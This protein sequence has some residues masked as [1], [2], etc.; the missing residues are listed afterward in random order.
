LA[1]V[2]PSA[3]GGV[4]KTALLIILLVLALGALVALGF[5]AWRLIANL[6][7][8]GRSLARSQAR[9]APIL[10]SLADGSAS[11]TEQAAR[12]QARMEDRAASRDTA[13]S[14]YGAGGGIRDGG[15]RD[16][17]GERPPGGDGD[18]ARS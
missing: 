13:R 16:R 11:A 5:T 7:A 2:G 4:L 8:L 3:R 6:N 15:A 14:R 18:V 10:Q 12:L 1:L 17:D 9:L